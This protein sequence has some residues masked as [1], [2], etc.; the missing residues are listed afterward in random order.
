MI[1]QEQ[2]EKT[3]LFNELKAREWEEL[4]KIIKE[5]AYK[6]GE[7]I[8]SEG[9]PTTEFYM[10]FKGEI[11]I[12][13]KIAPQLAESTVYVVRPFDVFGEFSFVDPK[14]RSATARC[15]EDSSL[16][17]IERNDFQELIDRFPRIGANFYYS[18]VRLLSERL[19]RMNNYLRET[20]V[21][22][23]GLNI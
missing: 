21:R 10:L 16:G 23:A 8:F 18:L 15:K 14:Q 7:I 20:F 12:Q 17:I 4:L 22:C 1:T 3:G 11:E 13:I 19:R 9:D 5:K 2:I 6:E